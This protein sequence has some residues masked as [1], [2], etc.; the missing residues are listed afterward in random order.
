MKIKSIEPT[1][2]PNSMK[3]VLDTP[4]PDGTSH[5]YKK[6]DEAQAPEPMFI[7]WLSKELKESIMFL[8]TL[9]Q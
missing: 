4:L 5:N 7:F 2:S 9:W 1:P 6:K 3:I 8:R